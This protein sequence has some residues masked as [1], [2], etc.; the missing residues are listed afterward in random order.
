MSEEGLREGKVETWIRLETG[1]VVGSVE[2]NATYGE[3]R[4]PATLNTNSSCGSCNYSR[5]TPM[6]GTG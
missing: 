2:L 4:Y 5:V 1:G 6:P 3:D